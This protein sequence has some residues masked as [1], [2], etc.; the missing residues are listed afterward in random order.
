[1][2]VELGFSHYGKNNIWTNEKEKTG[3]SRKL[4]SLLIPL[5][6]IGVT[7]QEVLNRRTH[8]TPEKD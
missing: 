4:D 7:E 6:V 1:V 5:H 3:N 8:S 2:G